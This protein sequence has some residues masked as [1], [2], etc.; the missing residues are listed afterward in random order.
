MKPECI[1]VTGGAGFI[2]SN[3]IRSLLR[4]PEVAR[5]LNLDALTYAGNLQNLSEI[6]N[7]ARYRFQEGRIQER[8]RLQQLLEEHKI[9]HLMHLAA[10]SH[11]DRSI[12]G[13]DN[14]METNIM[15]TFA[16]L[17]GCRQWQKKT[18]QWIKFLHVST[19]EVFGSLGT[20]GFFTEQTPYA[21][22][23]PYAAS[24]A[25]SDML[26]RSY[27]ATY[28]MPCTISNCSN[29]YGPYQFPEKLIPLVTFRAL[30]NESIPVYGQ[31]ENIRDWLFVGDHVEALHLAATQGQPGETYN[32][33]G[34]QECS[35]IELVRM[36]CR[37]L[38]TLK[39]RSDG[40]SYAGQIRFVEDR[41]GH[42]YRYAIDASK[43]RRELGWK[44]SHTLQDGLERTIKWY[45]SNPRW[46]ETVLAR[47][48][49][50]ERLG[51]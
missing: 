29:N 15:G 16:L 21:P 2:G 18:G 47:G 45:L 5:V 12:E 4:K 33:G 34:N 42:D 6:T 27:H 44:P 35:N 51:L 31:G 1:L 11:V 48:Y 10:E 41:P 49:E 19:D 50:L 24:K 17:E 36:I 20:E 28:G 46:C 14:F 26:V 22:N 40:E 7:D 43:I 8:E 3:L 37:M 9:T 13:P 38:D 39:P 32:I 30:K 23:S 25:S